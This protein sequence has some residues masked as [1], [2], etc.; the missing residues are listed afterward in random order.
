MHV[1]DGHDTVISFSYANIYNTIFTLPSSM[2]YDEDD[3]YRLERLQDEADWQAQQTSYER[4]FAGLPRPWWG[5]DAFAFFSSWDGLTK[6]GSGPLGQFNPEVDKPGGGPDR[7]F[8]QD[9]IS[10]TKETP[11]YR[12]ELESMINLP[13]PEYVYING[14]KFRKPDHPIV[15]RRR[16]ENR[17]VGLALPSSR[18]RAVEQ[19]KRIDPSSL[20]PDQ[21]PDVVMW[22]GSDILPHIRN[23]AEIMRRKGV[24]HSD[25][26]HNL[27]DERDLKPPDYLQHF[28][29]GWT[30]F[31]LD[32]SDEERRETK[33]KVKAEVEEKR[34]ESSLKRDLQDRM[35]NEKCSGATFED[36]LALLEALENNESPMD[37]PTETKLLVD[38]FKAKRRKSDNNICSEA[39][40]ELDI[41]NITWPEPVPTYLL[42]REG[43][44]FITK[45]WWKQPLRPPNVKDPWWRRGESGERKCHKLQT[46]ELASDVEIVD[47][48]PDAS[49]RF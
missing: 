45:Q 35:C 9:P 47:E 38:E 40:T 22:G 12:E 43:Y 42:E 36:R 23:E 44:Y 13:K 29:G 37:K 18:K 1:R 6:G 34:R 15:S 8:G 49:D 39:S 7:S 41:E 10:V 5:E 16:I 17:Q 30:P 26:N 20:I 28:A 46:D 32:E 2:D 3:P 31:N 19:A 27:R 25:Y 21:R 11:K 33:E 4:S 24:V 48:P 14:K